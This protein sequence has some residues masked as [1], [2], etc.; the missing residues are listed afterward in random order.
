MNN[1]DLEIE[2]LQ[3]RLLMEK[4]ANKGNMKLYKQYKDYLDEL[5]AMAGAMYLEYGDDDILYMTQFRKNRE[6]ENR[7]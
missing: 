3:I 6:I 4:E 5:K 1:K 7:E 2:I